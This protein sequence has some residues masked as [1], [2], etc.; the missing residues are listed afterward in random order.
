MQGDL[1]LPYHLLTTVE[2]LCHRVRRRD[3]DVAHELRWLVD[4]IYLDAKTIGVVMDNSNVQ[5]AASLYA[6]VPAPEARRL[7]RKIKFNFTPKH[8]S[9]LIV[10]E[11]EL[12]VLANQCLGGPLPDLAT[13]RRE[14]A[15]WETRRNPERPTV[16]WHFTTAQARRKLKHLYPVPNSVPIDLSS[17]GPEARSHRNRTAPPR[18]HQPASGSIHV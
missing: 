14:V 5:T 10:V 12:A 15:A 1:G 11:C 13:A 2:P 4:E 7:A 3:G 9:W 18:S 8:G 6:A 16:C 17:E